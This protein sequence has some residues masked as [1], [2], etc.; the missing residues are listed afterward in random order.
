MIEIILMIP[1]AVPQVIMAI[2]AG[3]VIGFLAVA[4]TGD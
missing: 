1:A 2:I 4:I 3:G